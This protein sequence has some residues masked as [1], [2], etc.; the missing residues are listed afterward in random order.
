MDIQTAEIEF[1]AWAEKAFRTSRV[2]IEANAN[3]KAA[4]E[5][6]IESAVDG[7]VKYNGDT[8]TYTFLCPLGDVTSVDFSARIKTKTVLEMQSLSGSMQTYKFFEGT[9]KLPAAL[10]GELDLFDFST[11]AGLFAFL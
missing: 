9:M 5:K 8:I 4:A 1:Y 6:I 10:V 2:K 11:L 7:R 3:R